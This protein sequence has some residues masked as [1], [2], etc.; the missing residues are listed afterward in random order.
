MT[1]AEALK[2]ATHRHYKGGLYRVIGSATYANSL[3][4]VDQQVIGIALHTETKEKVVVYKNWDNTLYVLPG[5]V[6]LGQTEGGYTGNP[7]RLVIYEHL[8]PHARGLFARPFDMFYGNLEDGTVRFDPIKR[9]SYITEVTDVSFAADVLGAP[10][11]T[12][13]DFWAPW[14]GPCKMLMPSLE[15]VAEKFYGRVK[16]V[17]MNV[18]DNT[19]IPTKYGVRGIPNMLAFVGGEQVLNSIGAKSLSQ[20][21]AIFDKLVEAHGAK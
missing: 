7:E 17:K 13:V 15:K 10:G 19:I 6:A 5:S 21:T 18:D 4:D 11:I 14:C 1:E 9:D 16:V 3:D 20:V 8:F 2:Q 12:V